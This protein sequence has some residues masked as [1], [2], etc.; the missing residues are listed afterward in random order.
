MT[1][2]EVSS[3]NGLDCGIKLYFTSIKNWTGVCVLKVFNMKSESNL[4]KK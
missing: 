3:T 1:F 2:G 4:V